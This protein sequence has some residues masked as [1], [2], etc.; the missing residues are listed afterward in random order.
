MGIVVTKERFVDVASG[1][2]SCCWDEVLRQNNLKELLLIH[3]REVL[4]AEKVATGQTA[5]SVR[6]QRD[7]RCC[8]VHWLPFM[9]CRA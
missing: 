1:S 7:E 2:F 6:K 9:H 4:R 3:N 5:F 8:Q